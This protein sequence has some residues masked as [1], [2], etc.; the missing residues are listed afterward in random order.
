MTRRLLLGGLTL[1][2]AYVGLWAVISPLSFYETF[3]GWHRVWVAVDGP[4][5]EHLVRDVGALYLALGAFGA[6]ALLWR[7][8]RAQ[9]LAGVA[10]TVFSLPHLTYHLGHLE[11]FNTFDKVANVVVL[12][13]TLAAA[14]VVA[15]PPPR[16]A[17]AATLLEVE[18]GS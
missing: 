9:T 15:I 13:A 2:A 6:G 18:V 3:P 11:H 7:D 5:N 17:E 14:I 4:Y 1:S 10:W 12:G 16:H 8:T